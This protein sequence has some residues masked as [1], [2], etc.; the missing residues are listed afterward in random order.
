MQPHSEREQALCFSLLQPQVPFSPRVG[1]IFGFCFSG[2]QYKPGGELSEPTLPLC[3]HARASSCSPHKCPT[4]HPRQGRGTRPAEKAAPT[5]PT[6]RS[7]GTCWGNDDTFTR[8]PIPDPSSHSDCSRGLSQSKQ[9]LTVQLKHNPALQPCDAAK[10]DDV[11]LE[12]GL[13]QEMCSTKQV[14]STSILYPEL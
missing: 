10:K 13:T 4:A 2:S 3:S 1:C 6:S 7:P 11:E 9:A 8:G 5:A 12:Q 14:P